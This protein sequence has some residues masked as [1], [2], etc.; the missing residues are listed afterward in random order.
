M[1]RIMHSFLEQRKQY[2]K[3]YI[4]IGGNRFFNYSM[5]LCGNLTGFR[6]KILLFSTSVRFST[7]TLAYLACSYMC[8][9][10]LKI[11]A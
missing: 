9:E 3:Q 6:F 10:A 8:R 11:E 7:R 1:Q 2:Q 5:G 4:S